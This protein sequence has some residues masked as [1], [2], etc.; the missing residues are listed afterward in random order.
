[1]DSYLNQVKSG[2]QLLKSETRVRWQ[3]KITRV[4]R[5]YI[6]WNIFPQFKNYNLGLLNYKFVHLEAALLLVNC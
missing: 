1:M 5:Q 6:K 3:K 4:V 2:G